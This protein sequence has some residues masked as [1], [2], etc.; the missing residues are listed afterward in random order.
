MQVGPNENML[1]LLSVSVNVVLSLCQSTII[2]HNMAFG[3]E[4][5]NSVKLGHTCT[6]FMASAPEEPLRFSFQL[7]SK[8]VQ[9]PI[10][11][12][13]AGRL[14]RYLSYSSPPTF[15]LIRRAKTQPWKL[16]WLAE[17]LRPSWVLAIHK[18][19]LAPMTPSYIH[20]H[21]CCFSKNFDLV[22]WHWWDYRNDVWDKTKPFIGP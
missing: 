7:A 14:Q 10:I 6:S 22:S 5:T 3:L 20:N 2:T 9:C 12:S 13:G 1:S 15:V 4:E 19:P 8:D 21:S 17:R 16:L 11:D 18:Q